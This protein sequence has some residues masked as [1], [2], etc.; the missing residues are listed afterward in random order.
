VTRNTSIEVIIGT[1]AKPSFLISERIY[2][3]VTDAEEEIWLL[4][5]LNLALLRMK[6]ELDASEQMR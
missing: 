1:Q 4:R 2:Q 3:K 6:N 5:T